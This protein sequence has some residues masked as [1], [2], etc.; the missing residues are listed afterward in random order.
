MVCRVRDAGVHQ[1]N[2]PGG[3][4]TDKPFMIWCDPGKLTGVAWYDSAQE[5]FGSWQYDYADLKRKLCDF[6]RPGL[7]SRLQIG[8]ERYIQL[9][10]GYGESEHSTKAIDLIE[11]TAVHYG[12]KVLAPRPAESRKLG[13]PE[14]LK[15]L[16]WWLP[17][18]VHANDAAQHLLAHLLRNKPI[19]D[20]VQR[21][22][23]AAEDPDGTLAS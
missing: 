7:L 4:M 11:E 9:P 15:R 5:V 17:G 2:Q 12:F 23:F 20:H 6:V 21:T 22:L 10:G 13:N 18:K 19:P 8:Y 3:D 16:G 14:F 1:G